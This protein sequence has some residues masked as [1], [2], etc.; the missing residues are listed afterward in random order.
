MADVVSSIHTQKSSRGSFPR[1]EGNI[2]SGGMEIFIKVPGGKRI[3]LQVV[4]SDAVK[5]VKTKI[6]LQEGIPP[7]E[8]CLVSALNGMKLEDH[9][10]LRDYGIDSGSTLLLAP[11]LRNRQVPMEIVVRIVCIP[12]WRK[13]TLGVKP[14]DSIAAVKKRIQQKEPILPEPQCL[15]FAGKELADRHTLR[16]YNIRNGS[17]LLLKPRCCDYSF[18]E[19]HLRFLKI[20]VKIWTEEKIILEVNSADTIN[21]VKLKIQNTKGIPSAQQSFMFDGEQLEDSLTLSHYNIENESTLYLTRIPVHVQISVKKLTGTTI[22]VAVE[23]SNTVRMLKDK[24]KQVEDFLPG[25]TPAL[26]HAGQ[27]LDDDI[28]L[29]QHG[30]ENESILHEVYLGG[31]LT[32]HFLFDQDNM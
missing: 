29:H 23:P 21:D 12:T 2:P 8:Q 11:K 17:S 3:I 9:R 25:L 13:V 27:R 14:S 22:D 20:H 19:E 15:M 24:V 28:T 32:E 26:A 10:L 4:P 1:V 18:Q 31:M 7:E 16:K 30:I 5:N 6:Q